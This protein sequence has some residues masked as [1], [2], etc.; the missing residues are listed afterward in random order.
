M[1]I[2]GLARTKHNGRD[3][4]LCNASVNVHRR[5]GELAGLGQLIE[6]V[7][8]HDAL[9]DDAA[10]RRER[11]RSLLPHAVRRVAAVV[12]NLPVHTYTHTERDMPVNSA[13]TR[14]KTLNPAPRW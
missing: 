1:Y 6:T 10:Q 9:L 4:Y 2:S 14:H 3:R 7:N 12:Q 5:Y 8:S 13:E 11:R